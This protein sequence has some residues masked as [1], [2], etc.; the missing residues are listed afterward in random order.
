[1]QLHNINTREICIC[2]TAELYSLIKCKWFIRCYTSFGIIKFHY[3][4]YSHMCNMTVVCYENICILTAHVFESLILPIL[5]VAYLRYRYTNMF[6]IS[7][8][9]ILKNLFVN[10]TYCS[11]TLETRYVY[12]Y[13]LNM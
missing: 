2:C 3:E 10:I 4:R 6:T 13:M 11:A 1:M 12:F 5:I 7:I 8:R 9:E